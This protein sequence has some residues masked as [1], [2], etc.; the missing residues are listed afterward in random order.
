M[1]ALVVLMFVFGFCLCITAF[2]NM[3]PG[4]IYFIGLCV[5]LYIAIEIIDKVEEHK[6][7]KNKRTEC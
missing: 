6:Q 5:I 3:G 4:A 1:D 7:K 2:I